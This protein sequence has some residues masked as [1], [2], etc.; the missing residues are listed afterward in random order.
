M[1]IG[2]SIS[3]IAH[4]QN[5]VTNSW[6]GGSTS[7]LRWQGSGVIEMLVKLK[8]DLSWS[9]LPMTPITIEPPKNTKTS[10]FVCVHHHFHLC[11]TER[12]IDWLMKPRYDHYKLTV[13]LAENCLGA[14]ISLSTDYK[15]AL[16][17]TKI[18]RQ[19][20]RFIAPFHTHKANRWNAGLLSERH[21]N[22]SGKKHVLLFELRT[23]YF[24]DRA[25]I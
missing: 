1:Q 4:L 13:A 12:L 24:S 6:G 14:G 18:D 17:V 5:Q 21:Y 2:I 16:V 22:W 10:S 8:C 9:T 15:H 23:N 20:W 7:T 11:L 25:T 3:A 19:Q